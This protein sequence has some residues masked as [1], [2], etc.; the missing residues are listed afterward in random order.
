MCCKASRHNMKTFPVCMHHVCEC[1]YCVACLCVSVYFQYGECAVCDI[2]T[3][4]HG[5]HMAAAVDYSKQIQH[6][7]GTS[8]VARRHCSVQGSHSVRTM[9][10]SQQQVPLLTVNTKQGPCTCVRQQHIATFWQLALEMFS[11]GSSHV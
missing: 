11:S 3:W 4:R 6:K 8:P 2:S 7:G 5:S 10:H 1:I 9:V